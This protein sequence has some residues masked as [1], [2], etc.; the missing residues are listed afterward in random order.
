[1]CCPRPILW[2]LQYQA[3][4]NTVSPCISVKWV[5]VSTATLIDISLP[6]FRTCRPGPS[7]E[8]CDRF[9]TGDGPLYMAIPSESP[10]AK[11]RCDVLGVK[12]LY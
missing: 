2:G 3:I 8:V 11:E 4:S 12:F 1:M 9:D 5:N 10:T 7:S 6:T